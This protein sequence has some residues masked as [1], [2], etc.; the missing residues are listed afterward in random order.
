MKMANSFFFGGG[1]GGRG[2]GGEE[3]E[4]LGEAPPLL[5]YRLPKTVENY[6]N[7]IYI[8]FSYSMTPPPRVSESAPE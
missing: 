7:Q 2:K 8:Q 3:V 6:D 1:G 5:N 4:T